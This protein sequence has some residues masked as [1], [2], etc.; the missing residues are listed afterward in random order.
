MLTLPVISLFTFVLLNSRWE[1]MAKCW[2]SFKCASEEDFL[3]EDFN[4]FKIKWREIWPPNTVSFRIKD[5]KGCLN[6]FFYVFIKINFLFVDQVKR[7]KWC[8][9][10]GYLQVLSIINIMIQYYKLDLMLQFGQNS[11]EMK[12]T[13]SPESKI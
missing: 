4:L 6:L 8:H 10:L 1:L 13:L 2:Y 11:G 5:E 9:L 7:I 3:L 12:F